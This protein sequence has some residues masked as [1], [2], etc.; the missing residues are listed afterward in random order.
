MTALEQYARLEAAGL[1]RASPGAQRRDVI[2][3]L[4]EASLTITDLQDR[5]LAHWS[6]AAVARA[7]PG[8]SPAL[9][10]PDG[11]PGEQLELGTG[12]ED[13]IDAIER[14]RR[15]VDRRR[16]RPGRLRLAGIAAML[17]LGAVI[18]VLWLPGAMREH[19]LRVLPPAKRTEISQALMAEIIALSG[20]PC[21][22]ED[23]MPALD[24]LAQRVL[25]SGGEGRLVVLR[26]GPVA[27]ASL[28]DGR[29]LMAR[30]LIEDPAEPDVP[31]GF[32]LA[33]RLRQAAQDPL[34]TL[35]REGGVT[36]SFGLLTSGTLPPALLR[37]H[38]QRLLT[39]RPATVADLALLQAFEDAAISPRPYA[40]ARDVTGESVLGLIEA[41]PFARTKP[42]PAL[43]D[44]DW[45]RLQG[46]CG[47]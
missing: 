37:A 38:A 40:L 26:D 32:V 5:A 39:A 8:E 36:A 20:R 2:V 45:L 33:E 11:D 12:S 10:H 15:A 7:N 3:S 4:G 27:T 9:Y 44:S 23:G 47:A 21:R 35:V 13:M 46:I 6:L 18:A 42:R 31:A 34:E 41:A 29:I 24:A 19:A 43:T 22:T 16:P 1:W 14:V 30:A 28:P 25:G 17:L